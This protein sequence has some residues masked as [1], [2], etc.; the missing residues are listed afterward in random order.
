MD[1]TNDHLEPQPSQPEPVNGSPV[2]EN[3]RTSCGRTV[4][5]PGRYRDY[6]RL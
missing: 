5:P 6:V 3:N 4:R 1:L 2:T